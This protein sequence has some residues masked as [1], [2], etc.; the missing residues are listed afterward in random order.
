VACYGAVA[1]NAR[2]P[3]TLKRPVR[4]G[5]GATEPPR[6][7][8]AYSTGGGG[9]QG[10]GLR[11]VL[12]RDALGMGGLFRTVAGTATSP[13]TAC[14]DQLESS[15]ASQN[16]RSGPTEDIP[17]WLETKE[18]ATLAAS[19]LAINVS[20]LRD[21]IDGVAAKRCVFVADLSVC[22]LGWISPPSFD[23]F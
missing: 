6:R 14:S 19:M 8:A 20:L 3:I 23:L 15:L 1:E 10:T 5:S 9:S 11:L 22:N 16:V 12:N 2:L 17:Q 18:T 7:R 4:G 13:L 21:T